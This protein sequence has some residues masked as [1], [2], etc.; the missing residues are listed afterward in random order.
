GRWIGPGC[1][2][3]ALLVSGLTLFEYLSGR[4][5]RIDEALFTDN[6]VPGQLKPGR[7]SLTTAAGLAMLNAALL[8]LTRS[9]NP[10]RL[11]IAGVLGVLTALLGAF[12]VLSWA[13]N[14]AFGFGWSGLT[15]L[16]LH[17]A[18]LFTILGAG[19]VATAW[20]GTDLVWSI[21]GGPLV[22]FAMGLT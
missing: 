16:A 21:R 8:F 15:S 18:I 11:G 3:A 10:K 1:S 4:D 12:A 19:C 20:Q 17:T 7:I 2:W 6:S 22:G 14:I 13:A 9:A 5:L